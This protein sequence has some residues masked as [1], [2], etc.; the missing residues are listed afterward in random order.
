MRA[1][2]CWKSR[3]C[4]E[5][6]SILQRDAARAAFSRDARVSLAPSPDVTTDEWAFYLLPL[7]DDILSMEL[8]EFFR[9]NFLVSVYLLGMWAKYVVVSRCGL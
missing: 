6:S 1:T 2:P 3:A 4:L 8:P 7:D 5:V 9:D